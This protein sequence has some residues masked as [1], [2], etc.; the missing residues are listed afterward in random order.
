MEAQDFHVGDKVITMV[1]NVKVHGDVQS[2]QLQKQLVD[3]KIYQPGHT[4]HCLIVA[5]PPAEITMAADDHDP[6][7][8]DPLEGLTKDDLRQF[9]EHVD[10]RITSFNDHFLE[11]DRRMTALESRADDLEAAKKSKNH[12]A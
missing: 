10:E 2:I 5:R 8:I 11:L 3:I 4:H 1:N 7:P 6:V 12:G 9:A